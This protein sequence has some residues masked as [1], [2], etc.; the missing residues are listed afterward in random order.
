MTEINVSS[1]YCIYNIN[2]S[3]RY[4]GSTANFNKRKQ[5]HLYALLHHRSRSKLMQSD[6]D[7]Y[8]EHSFR[9]FVLEKVKTFDSDFLLSREQEWMDNYKPEYNT[10]MIAGSGFSESAR[11]L[12]ATQKRASKMRGRKRSEESKR[13]QSET[14]I[15]NGKHKL[16]IVTEKQRKHLSEINMGDK[17][18]NWGLHRSAESKKR[19]SGIMAKILYTFQSPEGKQISVRNLNN[20]AS[21]ILGVPVSALTRLRDG[22]SKIYKGWTF[23]SA[24]KD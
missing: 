16:K 21:N 22:R 1:V 14:A 17:N 5:Q 8:G 19:S 23:I 4:V 24:M 13:K 3:R 11:S 18:P 10:L 15:K 9:F 12:E 6:F 20:G 2:T 7:L